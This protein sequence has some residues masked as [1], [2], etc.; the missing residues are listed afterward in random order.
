MEYPTEMKATDALPALE[1]PQR[2]RVLLA[3]GLYR[4]WTVMTGH[5]YHR[6]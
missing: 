2:R 1:S 6:E 3:E 4:A 5:P